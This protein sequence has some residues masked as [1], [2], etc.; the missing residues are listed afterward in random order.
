SLPKWRKRILL[1]GFGLSQRLCLETRHLVEYFRSLDPALKVAW[2][3]NYREVPHQAG[4]PL[5]RPSWRIGGQRRALRLV[6][7]GRIHAEKGVRELL[8]VA[9]VLGNTVELTLYGPADDKRLVEQL[10]DNVRHAGIFENQ[11]AG[12]IIQLFD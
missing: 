4:R 8:E 6:Y 5:R 7:V 3:P 10:P 1:F 12:E 2:F 9:K 11:F